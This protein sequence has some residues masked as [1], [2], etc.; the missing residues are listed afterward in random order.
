MNVVW[1]NKEDWRLHCMEKHSNY[2]YV[3]S[4]PVFNYSIAIYFMYVFIYYNIYVYIK[5]KPWVIAPSTLGLC[6]FSNIV[7]IIYTK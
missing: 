3:N 5:V 2:M 1:C 7:E 4:L 6:I